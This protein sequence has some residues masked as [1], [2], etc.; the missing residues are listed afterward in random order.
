MIYLK[1]LL[2]FFEKVNF[3]EPFEC[4]VIWYAFLLFIDF[5]S[6]L[7]FSKHSFRNPIRVSYTFDTDQVCL[8]V[9]P[10]L[11]KLLADDTSRQRVELET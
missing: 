4:W 3:E 7:F 5:F 8:F 6:E 1:E 2:F 10:N 9:G 11:Q